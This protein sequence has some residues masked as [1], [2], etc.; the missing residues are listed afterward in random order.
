MNPGKSSEGGEEAKGMKPSKKAIQEKAQLQPDPAEHP[1][2][3][4]PCLSPSKAR[5]LGFHNPVT[6]S[7]WLGAPGQGE[8]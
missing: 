6:V 1:Q 8:G 3:L 2:L 7:H 4:S 5:E